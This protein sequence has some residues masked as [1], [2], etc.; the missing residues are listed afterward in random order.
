MY[1]TNADGNVKIGPYLLYDPA[2]GG[3]RCRLDDRVVSDGYRY[4]HAQHVH[5]G[6]AS[7]LLFM[8]IIRSKRFG[9][10]TR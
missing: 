9:G 6:R 4:G 10:R 2:P 8:D 5:F 7:L 1:P 3:W